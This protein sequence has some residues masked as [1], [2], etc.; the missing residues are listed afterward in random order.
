[1][2]DK[3]NSRIITDYPKKDYKVPNNTP[4]TKLSQIHY[5][6][7]IELKVQKHTQKLTKLSQIIEKKIELN[8]T[9]NT[10]KNNI[11]LK[12]YPPNN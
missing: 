6:K 8:S 4:K 9:K 11:T 12:D 7:N 10:P 3:N 1:M 2:V 5:P